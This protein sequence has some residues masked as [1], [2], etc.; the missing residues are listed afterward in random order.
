MNR[1]WTEPEIQKWYD[2]MPWL[3]GCN[4][5][6]SNCVNRLD[7]WQSV[8]R[9]EHLKTSDTELKMCDDLGFNTV[10][11]WLNFDVYYKE[12]DEFMS[13]LESY[14]ALCDKH[15][16]KVMLV[17]TYEEDLPD[18]DVFVPKELGEQKVYHNHFNRDYEHEAECKKA[19]TF[20]H[21]VEYPELK[22]LFYEMVERVVKRYRN[23]ERV[24]AWNIENE[25][26]ITIGD[27]AVPL[28]EEL[29]AFVRSLDPDQPL[30]AD[31]WGGVNEET[32]EFNSASEKTAF[33]LSDFISF[34]SYSQYEWFLTALYT[35]KN[36]YNRPIIVTEWLNRCNHN[37]VKEIYPLCMM[38]KVGC[39]CWGF[40]G[41]GTCTTEPWDSIWNSE[42][43]NA[44]F[45]YTKWQHDLYRLNYR[46][47]DP[48]E[49]T[50]IKRCNDR[51]DRIEAKRHQK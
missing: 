50:L 35:L 16:Q 51:A 42:K 15:H 32:G 1:K 12:P 17:V 28:M 10:R 43:P 41:G 8:G 45:D 48:N 25:P 26:G 31:V 36:F 7:M 40:V 46:P 49:T 29:F 22:P 2:E 33:E 34:H 21:Y 27:R 44:G 3:R 11:L 18:G 14:I 24:F 23:D 38:E 30:T 39:Y 9:E 5:L 6:P 19:G 47:Y 20:R 37:N 13:T 4:F